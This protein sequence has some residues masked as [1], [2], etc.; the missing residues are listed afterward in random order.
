MKDKKASLHSFEVKLGGI[1]PVT[2]EEKIDNYYIVHTKCKQKVVITM[3]KGN[4]Q[5]LDKITG[6]TILQ[7]TGTYNKIT[8]GIGIYQKECAAHR[9]LRYFY[10]AMDGEECVVAIETDKQDYASILALLKLQLRKK[11]EHPELVKLHQKNET[12]EGELE[13]RRQ[14]VVQRAS[15]HLKTSEGPQRQI[16]ELELKVHFP[17]LSVVPEMIG[18]SIC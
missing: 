11:R 17:R 13:E 16:E 3:N 4:L 8:G 6:E 10:R 14:H 7:H 1:R 5:I 15:S 2:K 18:S 9:Y 12:S